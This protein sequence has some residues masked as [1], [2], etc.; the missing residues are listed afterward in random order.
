MV[1]CWTDTVSKGH[2]PWEMVSELFEFEY[3]VDEKGT[4]VGYST[5][6]ALIAYVSFSFQVNS[7]AFH[8]NFLY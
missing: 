1:D 8:K 4:I 3:G 7:M 6:M 5:L 2:P